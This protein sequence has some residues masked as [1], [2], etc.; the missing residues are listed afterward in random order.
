M[1]NEYVLKEV[2]RYSDTVRVRITNGAYSYFANK[3]P[4]YKH[5]EDHAMVRPTVSGIYDS[6]LHLF[7]IICGDTESNLCNDFVGILFIKLFREY[8]QELTIEPFG[9]YSYH[10]PES[11]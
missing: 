10:I 3:R 9:G 4:E 1:G 2:K 5:S 8:I 7:Q 6:I 11:C